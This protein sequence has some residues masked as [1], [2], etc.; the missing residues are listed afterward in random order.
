MSSAFLKNR[1]L[2]LDS[3]FRCALECPNCQRSK[4]F[5][6]NVPGRDLS[7]SAFVKLAEFFEEIHFCGQLSDPVHHPQFIE[8]LKIC[9]ER[10][11]FNRIHNASSAKSKDWYIKAFQANPDARWW[12]G[13]DGLPHQSHRYRINQDGEKLF[14][15][16]LEAKKHLNNRPTWQ[17][18]VFR[19]NEYNVEQAKQMAIKNG[20]NFSLM[21]SS[22]WLGKDDPNMPTQAKYRMTMK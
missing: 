9:N 22:R 11:I 20:V 15:I 10:K 5:K 13:I 14:D 8:F 3:T 19:Y 2:N 16:M 7:M 6:G 1:Q 17:Y 12:F 21:I 4:H 18:I